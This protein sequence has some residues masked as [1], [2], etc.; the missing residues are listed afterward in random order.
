LL[1]CGGKNKAG[2]NKSGKNKAGKNKESKDEKGKNEKG[3]MP[4]SF[5]VLTQQKPAGIAPRGL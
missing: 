3:R 5:L 4:C 2:K 1:G